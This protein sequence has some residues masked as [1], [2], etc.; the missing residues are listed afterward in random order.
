MVTRAPIYDVQI[1][2]DKWLQFAVVS[3]PGPIKCVATATGT[4]LSV[5]GT[6]HESL[7]AIMRDI[8]PWRTGPY[9]NEASSPQVSTVNYSCFL[10]QVLGL[11][12]VIEISLYQEKG[13]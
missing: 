9:V 8:W 3:K 7:T 11:F 12:V 4:V 6:Q 13:A 2:F 5:Q 10:Q 1:A